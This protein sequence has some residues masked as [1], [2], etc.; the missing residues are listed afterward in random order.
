MKKQFDLLKKQFDLLKKQSEPRSKS[1]KHR[2]QRGKRTQQRRRIRRAHIAKRPVA[3]RETAEALDGP[4]E[5]D[6]IEQGRAE[7]EP[8]LQQQMTDDELL[9]E[10][11]IAECEAEQNALLEPRLVLLGGRDVIPKHFWNV[12][13]VYG[14]EN[15][16]Q[17]FK[18]SMIHDAMIEKAT[19]CIR[20]NGP[21][22]VAITWDVVFEKTER[23]GEGNE[24]LVQN[25][26]TIHTGQ[27]ENAKLIRNINEVAA[28]I[29]SSERKC[30]S[31]FETASNTLVGSGFTYARTTAFR[32]GFLKFRFI[33]GR[34]HF[35]TPG[36]LFN[37]KAVINVQNYDDRCFMWAV[38]AALHPAENDAERTSKYENFIG[39][40]N[41]SMLDF[42]V[43]RE[44]AK[45]IASFEEKNNVQVNILSVIDENFTGRDR[46]GNFRTSYHE[47]SNSTRVANLLFL[48]EGD[49]SHYFCIRNMSALLTNGG[50]ERNAIHL[51]WTCL[52]CK[53]T[54]EDLQLH[55]AICESHDPYTPDHPVP[56]K[57]FISF[58]SRPRWLKKQI[59]I[60]FAIY[61]DFES[62][63]VA[64]D[65]STKRHKLTSYC[66]RLVSIIPE[67]PS[68][69][70]F[71]RAQGEDENVAKR[72]V[73]FLR[74]LD[75]II[76]EAM[77]KNVDMLPLT[78]DEV[79]AYQEAET[80][81][82]CRRSFPPEGFRCED[83]ASFCTAV[84]DDQ[85]HRSNCSNC[86]KRCRLH[87]LGGDDRRVRD[88]DNLTGR[89]RGAAHSSCKLIYNLKGVRVPVYFHNGQNYDFHFIL[90][91][92][93]AAWPDCNLSGIPK[94]FER[95][96][97]VSLGVFDLRDSFQM[98][99]APLEKLAESLVKAGKQTTHL[100]TMASER[101]WPVEVLRRKGVFPYE[102][103]T[104]VQQFAETKLPDRQ[105]FTSAISG[106]ISEEDYTRAQTAWNELGCRTFGEYHDAYLVADV[107]LLTDV[108][109]NFRSDCYELDGIDPAHSI[110][111]PGH[112]QLCLYKF[113]GACVDLHSNDPKQQEIFLMAESGK[114]G[115]ICQISK[116]YAKSDEDTY[117]GYVDA[118]N[119]YGKAMCMKLPI[120][121]YKFVKLTVEQVLEMSKAEWD[122]TDTGYML[123]IDGFWPQ[124]TH[125][126]LADYPPLPTQ[127]P[128]TFSTFMKGLGAVD[129]DDD[130]LICDFMPKKDYVVH[131][132]YLFAAIRLGFKLTNVSL[133]VSFRQEAWMSPYILRNANKRKELHDSD[134][135]RDVLKLLNNAVFGKMIENVRERRDLKP[136]MDERKSQKW[137]NNTRYRSHK[138][139]L[140]EDG[141]TGLTMIHLQKTKDKFDQPMTT[142]QA[143]LDLSKLIMLDAWYRGL[144]RE[145]GT[146]IKMLMTDTDSFIYEIPRR[147]M[148]A[149]LL[150]CAEY[151]DFSSSFPKG[152][153]LH[154]ATKQNKGV[155]GKLKDEMSGTTLDEFVGLRPK[156]YSI[157][158]G[159][160]ST[161]KAKG[162]PRRT[163]K[164]AIRHEDYL[165]AVRGG[166][167]GADVTF[168]KIQSREHKLS[169][170][171]IS[172][173]GLCPLDNKRW[174]LDD[175]INSLPHGHKDIAAR[176]S[177]GNI[178][179]AT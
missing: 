67:V 125:D 162:I 47:P 16:P 150:R 168:A 114:R 98:L 165:A 29:D 120:G 1:D 136:V 174:V 132:A 166:Q 127:K 43:T 31:Q 20:Q 23:D 40:Y 88:H 148:E 108:M 26:R 138:H 156:M 18:P 15:I 32:L 167:R 75:P 112:S 24:R 76:R 153:A 99:A 13:T 33:P 22:K 7:D 46:K 141:Q 81:H 137:I 50:N 51:C 145:F 151:L 95:F 79:R 11:L 54:D 104:S 177:Q 3:E 61:A 63:M 119:L 6:E 133:A 55:R 144:K 10:M 110:T 27:F 161:K 84:H 142:G 60:P 121:D 74:G 85:E 159:N 117:L 118:N 102:W 126:L 106:E 149:G 124:E 36:W 73:Q 25:K 103:F 37:K 93:C 154:E 64:V 28:A 175:G 42:P 68:R 115:G 17:D 78:D 21:C 30:A 57:A 97:N 129:N 157:K 171:S 58:L 96:A 91:E 48:T 123:T 8:D 2:A 49:K 143:I 128:G 158:A 155:L 135:K 62:R 12:E 169:T 83:C 122:A 164:V 82:I 172:K 19:E 179:A 71:H 70:E 89:F 77:K 53:R 65:G 111:L 44:S 90:P 146:D 176:D 131:F 14:L 45:S 87:Q 105:H 109:E 52:A 9:L 147:R 116:R 107:G 139:Y 178:Q 4:A 86:K 140:S 39:Q 35:K 152:H 100:S 56:D 34:R 101:G 163:V 160:A 5:H 173:K 66:A 80:C 41:W 134:P 94:T 130:K 69:T 38:L 92:V 113:T 170:Q 72:F 59:M